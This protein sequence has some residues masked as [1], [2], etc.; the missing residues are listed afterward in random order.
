MIRYPVIVKGA[1]GAAVV[2]A[3]LIGMGWQKSRTASIQI[4]KTR[5]QGPKSESAL[6]FDSDTKASRQLSPRAKSVRKNDVSAVFETTSFSEMGIEDLASIALKDP[7]QV[8]RRLAFS[9]LLAEMTADN[10]VQIREQLMKAGVNPRDSEWRDFNYAWGTIAGEAA[11]SNSLDM[12]KKDLYSVI[13]GWASNDPAGAMAILE[14]LPENLADQKKRLE[15]GIVAGLADRNR[16]EATNYISKLLNGGRSDAAR[17]ME[18]VADEVIRQEGSIEASNWVT[19]LSD[20]PLKGSAMNQVAERYAQT[21]PES[22]AEWIQEFAS[23]EYA[24][25]AVAEV[26]EKWAEREPLAAVSWLNNL[27]KGPGQNAG[28]N[29]AFGDW[30]DRDPIAA[31]QYLLSMP[32]SPKRDS[33]IRGFAEGYA[34][35]DPKTAIAWAQDIQDPGMRADSLKKVGFAYYRRKPEEAKTWLAESGLSSEAQAEILK[36]QRR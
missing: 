6:S 14:R 16:N 11:F 1:W 5:N 10:A 22:A 18:T 35:Q 19:T 28:L 34:W 7:N 13:S 36:S 8:K 29:S 30:E 25:R 15:E 33:A 3:F 9:S 31:G 2:G 17:L 24:T 4:P 32:N 21:D 12:E 23:E 27:P 20:G 26:G